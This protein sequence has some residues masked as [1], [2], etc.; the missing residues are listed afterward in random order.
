MAEDLEAA[1][2]LTDPTEISLYRS[3][4][5][6]AL[7]IGPDR[8]NIQNAVRYLA[9]FLSAPTALNMAQVKRLG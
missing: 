7:H 8:P 2:P 1:Q 4:V 5:G 3:H 9:R 6:V